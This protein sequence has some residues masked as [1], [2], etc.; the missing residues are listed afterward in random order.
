MTHHL[1]SRHRMRYCL[2]PLPIS[3]T[4]HRLSG[5]VYSGYFGSSSSSSYPLP[6]V[7]IETLELHLQSSRLL[8]SPTLQRL[9]I[10]TILTIIIQTIINIV[11]EI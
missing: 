11:N 2:F 3:I 10:G 4:Y 5:A 1:I 7:Y 6:R 8:N 9:Q